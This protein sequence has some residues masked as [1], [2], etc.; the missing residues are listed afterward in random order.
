METCFVIVCDSEGKLRIE[1]FFRTDLQAS[2]VR[3]LEWVIMRSSVEV[4]SEEGRAY[5]RLEAQR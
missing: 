2:L 4:T 3:I 5:L 1:V